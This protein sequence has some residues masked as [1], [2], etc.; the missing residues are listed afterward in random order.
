[1]LRRW[2]R[3]VA[4]SVSFVAWIGT[5]TAWAQNEP[6]PENPPA[7]FGPPPPG[8]E[9]PPPWTP[10]DSPAEPV[11]V[12]SDIAPGFM[13]LDRVDAHTRVGIQV[14]FD[15]WDELA[16]DEA[17]FMRF[18]P[19]GQVILP[20]TKFGLYGQA[21]ISHAF[22]DGEDGTGFSNLELGGFYMPLPRSNDLIL[23]A[24]LVAATATDPD[25]DVT[26]AASNVL[27]AY[28]RMTDILL[29]VPN[30]TTARLSASTVQQFGDL[31]LR[32]DGGFDFVFSRPSAASDDSNVFFRANV[33]GGYR[34]PEVVDL[35]AE[36]VNIAAV[37]G[38][39]SGGI[40]G[41]FLHTLAFSVRTPGVDQL[42]FGA[43]F[44]LDEDLRGEL[45]ILSLGYQRAWN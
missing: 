21:A 4:A 45:W 26:G 1:M 28:E 14:G 3:V 31:F 22:V 16:L 8:H 25:D 38:N 15:K 2:F 7:N 44:P 43:V 23:R 41:R 27:T 40:T 20:G 35:T 29:A 33:A 30:Y 18:N 34:V 5:A 10:G 9:P 39:V 19:Y 32:A 13:T 12:A 42:H 17:F 36:L 6:P 24:G 37:N 11:P